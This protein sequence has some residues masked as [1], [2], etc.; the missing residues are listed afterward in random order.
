MSLVGGLITLIRG[1]EAE[2]QNLLTEL[3]E[4]TIRLVWPNTKNEHKE[5]TENGIGI[6]N[7]R[8][9]THGMTRTRWFSHI[10]EATDEG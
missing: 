2:I 4:K 9:E 3:E 10:T 6:K 5:D 7:L 8:K 1:K